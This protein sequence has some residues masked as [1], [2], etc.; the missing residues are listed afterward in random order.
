MISI[1]YYTDNSLADDVDQFCRRELVKAAEGKRIISVSQK[2][3]ALGDNICVGE[4]GR[5]HLSL[6]KQMYAG[7]LEAKTK[8]IS[9]AEHDM[10][11]TPEHFNWRPTDDGAFW[12]NVNHWFVQWGGKRHG[13][14]TYHRRRPLSQLICARDIFLQ[15]VEEKIW[16][17]EHGWMIAKGVG[18]ACEPGCREPEEA[19]VRTAYVCEPGVK[20]D[21][22]G[23][24]MAQAQFKDLGKE[25]GRWTAKAFRTELPNLDIRHGGN[26]SG[27][28]RGKDAT[29]SLPYW[30][31]FDDAISGY[32]KDVV[33]G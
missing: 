26:F 9:L 28:R 8:Y 14:Y 24:L 23:F 29:Y 3:I 5:S 4:I 27:G 22:P 2:P 11:Y 1:I 17:L 16:M 18:G 25:V 7:G 13:E 20:D 21:S 15:A 33:N 12:Y 31:R 32:V 10:G 30:G 19:F 6:Y